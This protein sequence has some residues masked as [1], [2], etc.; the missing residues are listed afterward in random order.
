MQNTAGFPAAQRFGFAGLLRSGSLAL[1]RDSRGNAA[2]INRQSCPRQGR[3]PGKIA[4]VG[5]Y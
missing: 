5:E 3:R 1:T 4:G 2:L